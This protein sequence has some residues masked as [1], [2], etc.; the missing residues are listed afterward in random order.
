MHIP[1]HMI[2]GP[3]CPVTAV[4][5][6]AAIGSAFYFAGKTEKK[7]SP[8]L[9]AS[10]AALIFAA[11]MLN[12]P[13]GGGTSGHYLGAAFAAIVLGTP[14]GIMAMALVVTVQA[15]VFSDG[16]LFILGA[17]IL[18]MAV[19]G[20]GV[21]G[22]IYGWFFKD[23]NDIIMKTS[24]IF[25]LSFI[26]VIS[27]AAV[28]SLELSISGIASVREIFGVMLPVHSLIGM[29]EAVMTVF[30]AVVLAGLPKVSEIKFPRK[31]FMI[32][33]AFAMAAVLSHF[34]SVLPDGLEY[35]AGTLGL[36]SE[37]RPLFVT[38]LSDY[39]LF[40]SRYFL[41]VSAAGIAGVAIVAGISY[42]AGLIIGKKKNLRTVE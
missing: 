16:G 39:S 33:C 9:F 31:M 28:C 11:Q 13:I 3:V 34:A 29:A 37:N 5:A 6:A 10:V 35:S 40:G 17:N 4:L 7:P 24:G 32:I 2:N 1:E 36:L 26:S 8:S 19:I 42:L 12:F 23:K 14:F 38:P 20:A 21:S 30:F 18:N 15:L 22:F 41:A 27:S 25:F